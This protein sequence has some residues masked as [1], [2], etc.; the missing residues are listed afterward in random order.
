MYRASCLSSFTN[1]TSLT[2]SNPFVDHTLGP[3]LIGLRGSPGREFAGLFM[4]GIHSVQLVSGTHCAKPGAPGP[5][6]TATSKVMAVMV[7]IVLSA[8]VYMWY[9]YQPELNRRF[10]EPHCDGQ[11]QPDRDEAPLGVTLGMAGIDAAATRP[12]G[13]EL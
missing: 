8:A 5:T 10:R 2:G 1:L 11:L 7:T 4:L 3:C 6:A 12:A 13:D 9:M